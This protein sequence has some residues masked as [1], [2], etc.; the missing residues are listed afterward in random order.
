MVTHNG[1]AKGPERAAC[2][3][4]G[5]SLRVVHSTDGGYLVT[6]ANCD[7]WTTIPA[8]ERLKGWDDNSITV[9]SDAAA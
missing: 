9:M 2:Y 7:L 6:C 5:H 8:G 1:T 4:K 3:K